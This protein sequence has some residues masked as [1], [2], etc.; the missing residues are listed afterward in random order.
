VAGTEGPRACAG[1]G[2]NAGE[3]AGAVLGVD[4]ADVD[5]AGGQDR[6]AE[7]PLES[8][9]WRSTSTRTRT[10]SLPACAK[11]ARSWRWKYPLVGPGRISLVSGAAG[12][13]S[14]IRSWPV[15]GA[16]YR[17]GCM[18][19]ICVRSTSVRDV[20]VILRRKIK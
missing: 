20:G 8:G 16:G 17:R 9:S 5:G 10:I 15:G 13:K 6:W 2:Y 7:R 3:T 11:N 14:A 18:S 1:R 12:G 4:K 19:G